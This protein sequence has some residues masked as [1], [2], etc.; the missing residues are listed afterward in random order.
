M[1]RWRIMD[2]RK[3]I[4]NILKQ[5][6]PTVKLNDTLDKAL[7]V[8]ARDNSTALLVKSGEDLVG[9]ITISD[10]MYSLANEEDPQTIEVSAFMTKC[11]LISTRAVKTPC[12][13]LDEDQDLLAAIKVMNEAGVSHV[14]VSGSEGEPVGMVSSLDIIKHLA[15]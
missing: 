3:T 5:K 7:Q 11:E 13:Q 6:F 1:D 2:Y 14:L 10:I 15:S 8:M 12:V 9:V 4:K